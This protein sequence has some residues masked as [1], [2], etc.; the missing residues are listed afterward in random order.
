MNQEGDRKALESPWA[1]PQHRNRA[2][3]VLSFP[4]VFSFLPSSP[5]APWTGPQL[6]LALTSTPA[7]A[8]PPLPHFSSYQ[9]GQPPYHWVQNPSRLLSNH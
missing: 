1:A 6:F 2:T 4:L 9:F 8:S 7:S 5:G 3:L